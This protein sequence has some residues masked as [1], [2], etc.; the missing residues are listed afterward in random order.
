MDRL[1]S[2]EVVD[3]ILKHHGVL[4]MKWGRRRS[5]EELASVSVKKQKRRTKV[6]SFCLGSLRRKFGQTKCKK[7]GKGVLRAMD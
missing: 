7:R 4:G 6:S 2:K 1:A 3:H 5:R